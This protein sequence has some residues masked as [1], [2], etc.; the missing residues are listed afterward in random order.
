MVPV[1]GGRGD[2]EKKE[3]AVA[4]APWTGG[5]FPWIGVPDEAAMPEEGEKTAVGGRRQDPPAPIAWSRSARCSDGRL[6]ATRLGK[7]RAPGA[8][9]HP[10]M[11]TKQDRADGTQPTTLQLTHL[12]DWRHR[13]GGTSDADRWAGLQA[14]LG[15]REIR[16]KPRN[17][18]T[19]LV[20]RSL[21]VNSGALQG[22]SASL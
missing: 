11:G 20:T 7:W 12:G 2:L 13:A 16:W 17:S 5:G 21:F 1:Q 4:Q 3:T 10:C 8:Q 15:R 18:E 14:K 19:A 22:A 9:D 6:G